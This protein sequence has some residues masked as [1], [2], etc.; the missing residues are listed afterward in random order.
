MNDNPA[1]PTCGPVPSL[2]FNLSAYVWYEY[3]P[4][5]IPQ[6]SYIKWFIPVIYLTPAHIT[7]DQ[8]NLSPVPKS[9]RTIKPF[10]SYPHQEQINLTH[11]KKTSR[12]VSIQTL[13]TPESR[14]QIRSVSQQTYV[15]PPTQ[16]SN[17]DVYTSHQQCCDVNPN[18]SESGYA[19][20][21]DTITTLKSEKATPP[22]QFLPSNPVHDQIL[23]PVIPDVEYPYHATSTSSTNQDDHH[24]I[25]TFADSDS[26]SDDSYFDDKSVSEFSELDAIRV[27]KVLSEEV[28]DWPVSDI[29]LNIQIFNQ[30]YTG[31][32]EYNPF[33]EV[34]SQ[35]S[36]YSKKQL[37]KLPKE[38]INSTLLKSIE[39]L[40]SMCS[41]TTYTVPSHITESNACPN[42]LYV[43][44]SLAYIPVST[45]M[46]DHQNPFHI[47]Q[48]ENLTCDNW[49]RRYPVD[50]PTTDPVH[51]P[52][53][54][55]PSSPIPT[56]SNV[57]ARPD[58]VHMPT[59]TPPSNKRR[60]LSISS[61]D[62]FMDH[63]AAEGDNKKSRLFSVKSR[64]SPFSS[65]M[66][67]FNTN[68]KSSGNIL[69]V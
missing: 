35:L 65:I 11:E 29:L 25:D 51:M 58:P 53:Q 33:T 43:A 41:N 60:R 48:D 52:T 13:E 30:D 23:P 64:K 31:S 39:P 20:S 38:Y 62:G 21:S 24:V 9:H 59:Q 10:H 68:N 49:V 54:Y 4:P 12:S 22:R 42:P 40:E 3:H 32:T 17:D 2:Y 1:C 27:I 36:S 37:K 7:L 16:S 47:P 66:A 8:S 50:M 46:N 34:L 26:D 67:M 69:D 18:S 6:P 45:C 28:N 57:Q 56:R 5:G 15:D 44:D 61:D 55:S 63:D 19:S 14:P